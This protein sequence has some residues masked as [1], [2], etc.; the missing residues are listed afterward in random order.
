MAKIF[1][2]PYIFLKNNPDELIRNSKTY[3]EIIRKRADLEPEKVVYRFLEDGLTE[4]ETFTFGM[5]DRRSKALGAALQQHAAKGDRVLLLFPAGLKYVAAIFS[6]FYSGMIAVPAYPPRR[7]RNLGR[8]LSIVE[9][10]GAKTA[11]VTRQVYDD[12]SRNFNDHS[13]LNNM[14]WVIYEDVDDEQ[15]SAWK[16]TEVLPGDVALLQYTSGSTG[17]PKGV[18]LTQLNLLYNSEYIRLTFEF[19]KETTIGMNWLPIFHDMGLIGG[20]L[21]AGFLGAENIGMPPVQFIKTPG[22]WLQCIT[23]YK[24]TVGGGP[25]FGYDYCV[26]KVS[27]EEKKSLDLSSMKTFYCGAEPVRKKT[28]DSFVEYFSEC[29]VKATQMYPVYGLAEATLIVT[30]GYQNQPPVYLHVNKQKLAKNEVEPV[31]HGEKNAVLLTGVGKTWLETEVVIVN[32]ETFERAGNNEV[33]EIWVSGPTVAKGYWNK[34]EETERTFGAYIKSS[35]EGPFLR[36]GDLGFFHDN[37]LYIAGRLKDLI[38]IRGVNHYPSDIEFTV[39]NSHQDL[40]KNACAAFSVQKQGEEKLIIV[41]ELERNA[42]RKE[43]YE[44]VFDSVR[45]TLSEEHELEAEEIVLIRTGTIPLTSSGKI[46]RRQT[47]YDYLSDNLNVVARHV[48]K[49]EPQLK[50]TGSGKAS[51]VPTEENIKD[52]LIEWIVKNQHFSREQ[53][54][55]DKEIT[56][57][58][59]DSLSAVTL[60]QEISDYFGFEWH[61]SS[62]MMNPTINGLAKEGVKLWLESKS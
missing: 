48:K 41:Q 57:Y 33:G 52:W 60:E 37:E 28:M 38:I 6:C 55:L 13:I 45:K 10:A 49:P 35:G 29:G 32:P 23:R 5:L 22:R 34:P 25:N 50:Q 36:T 15:A 47:R 26:E 17:N 56:A 3:I 53:I 42:L 4:S 8:V 11:L 19:T 1:Y 51:V 62:F 21:Q 40:R 7:N 43:S 9:D 31:Q 30:G 16:E 61:V 20:I 27:E 14:N 2:M 12:I 59:I 18:M 39:S 58:G 24:A 54:S 44:D 46:Q